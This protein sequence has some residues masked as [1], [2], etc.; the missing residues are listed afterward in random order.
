MLQ[1][2]RRSGQRLSS[3][4]MGT[5]LS[6]LSWM[7]WRLTKTSRER[8]Q[9]ALLVQMLLLVQEGLEQQYHQQRQ[10][11]RL[12]DSQV[13]LLERVGTLPREEPRAALLAALGPLAQAL[14]RQDSLAVQHQ[15]ETRE[16]LLEV[17][18]T[19]VPPASEQIFPRIGQP[20]RRTSSPSSV[21]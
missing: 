5:W 10:V 17:L 19:Q 1:R 12:L 20:Q 16:L 4:C 15:Q 13:A 11:E 6:V 3:L 7:H 9:E 18:Q 21:S 2:A 8:K 14:Q